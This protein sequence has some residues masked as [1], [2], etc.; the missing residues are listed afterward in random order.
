MPPAIVDTVSDSAVSVP[1][2]VIYV[3]FLSSPSRVSVKE[4]APAAAARL[5]SVLLP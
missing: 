2:A 5:S 4:K 1:L 3:M